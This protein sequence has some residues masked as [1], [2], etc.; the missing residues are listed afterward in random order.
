MNTHGFIYVRTNSAY[1]NYC[2]IGKTIDLI[3]R[4]KQY[5]TYE[6]NRGKFEYI[7]EVIRE[8]MTSIENQLKINFKSFNHKIDAGTEYFD[9]NIIPLIIPFFNNNNIQYTYYDYNKMTH[10]IDYFITIPKAMTIPKAIT[11]DTNVINDNKIILDITLFNNDNEMSKLY[12]YAI[13]KPNFINIANILKY[14]DPDGYLYDKQNNNWYYFNGHLWSIDK[15]TN[16]LKTNVYENIISTVKKIVLFYE[17]NKNYKLFAN[18][19]LNKMVKYNFIKNVIN[20]AKKLYINNYENIISI[21]KSEA[22]IIIFDM[23]CIIN[24]FKDNY[25]FTGNKDDVI[26]IKDIYNEFATS[27]YFCNLTK[28]E[29]KK[30]NKTFFTEYVQTNIFFRKYYVE[31]KNNIRN[32]ISQWKKNDESE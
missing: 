16:N 6:I 14:L 18:K 2:K 4:N 27:S 3:K 5:I 31:R 15:Y 29:K 8:Q 30:Y 23:S 32:L 28:A 19:L 26:K 12:N 9:K 21:Q 11:N 10:I 22:K 17:N 7:F 25:I 1:E 13:N 20:E 24:L